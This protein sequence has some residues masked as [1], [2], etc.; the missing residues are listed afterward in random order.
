MG[1]QL[2]DHELSQKY[3]EILPHVGRQL[4]SASEIYQRWAGLPEG[5]PSLT[6]KQRNERRWLAITLNIMTNEGMIIR[7]ERD[8]PG[9]SRIAYMD[10]YAEGPA[11][12]REHPNLPAH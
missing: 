11:K 6:N 9:K 5:K 10:P 3:G 2:M 4:S 1:G 7:V 8:E 12:R